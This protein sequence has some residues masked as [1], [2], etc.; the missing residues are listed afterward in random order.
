MFL[1]IFHTPKLKTFRGLVRD[2]ESK[3]F[4]LNC[5]SILQLVVIVIIIGLLKPHLINFF[6][7]VLFFFYLIAQNVIYIS[8]CSVLL[9]YFKLTKETKR[10]DKKSSL[11]HIALFV[12]LT[13][14]NFAVFL[15]LLLEDM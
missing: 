13:T 6:I 1:K 7:L 15:I 5:I 4:K 8:G 3:I 14:L 2:W 12:V 11:M 10:L 9:I